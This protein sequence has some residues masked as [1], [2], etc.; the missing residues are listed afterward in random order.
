LRAHRR[1]L[2]FPPPDV[3]VAP[4]ELE[5]LR[6]GRVPGPETGEEAESEPASPGTGQPMA[7]VAPPDLP[8]ER[9]APPA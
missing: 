5:G 3:L 7:T 9:G 4:E 8:P 2:G 1:Y 6:Q